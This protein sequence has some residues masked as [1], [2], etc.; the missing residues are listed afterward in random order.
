[1]SYDLF[2]LDEILEEF[3][4]PDSNILEKDIDLIDEKIDEVESENQSETKVID[5]NVAKT[6][7]KDIE[8]GY[9]FD[10]GKKNTD[11][12]EFESF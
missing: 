3:S 2:L 1:M 5:N 8:E 4:E 7:K 11:D 12:D 9:N 6:T 10:L